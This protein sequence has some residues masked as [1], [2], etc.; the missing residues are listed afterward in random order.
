MKKTNSG[1]FFKKIS[2]HTNNV[3]QN[4]NTSK[5]FAGLMIIII[6]IGSKFVHIKI[7]KSMEAYLKYTFSKQILVFAIA[8]VGTRDVYVALF[9]VVLFT[10]LFEFI[11]NEESRF[12]CL[13]ETFTS[14]HLDLLENNSNDNDDKVSDEDIAKAKAILEKAAKQDNTSVNKNTIPNYIS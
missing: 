2:E 4:L 6:N 12:C 3:V 11:L 7:S 1:S 8:W 5:I 10:I 14:Y 13:P 9:I